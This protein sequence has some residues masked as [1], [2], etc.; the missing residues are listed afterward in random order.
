MTRHAASRGPQ[1]TLER[2][3]RA[4]V[5]P[6]T[7]DEA[8]R[9]VVEHAGGPLLVLAGPGTGKTTTLVEAIVDRIEERGADPAS[10]L[11]LTF[12][13]KAAEQLR[14]RVTAR[15]GRTVASPISSTFHS[16]AYSLV[17]RFTPADLYAAPLRLLT[18]PQADVMVRDLLAHHG[19]SLGWPPGLA[20]AARTRG[21]AK[22]VAA[23][24]AR[25]REKGAD[26]EQLVAL[27]RDSDIPEFV[28]AGLFLEH[29]LTNLD[30]HGATDY[31]DLVRRAVIEAQSHREELRREFSHVFVDEYQDTDPGQVALLRAI[32]GDGLNLVAVGDPHQSIYGFRGAEVR[33]ILDF[34]TQFP[35][36]T[37]ERAPVVVLGTTRRF[38]H[39]IL[40]AATRVSDNLPLVGGIPAE[41]A[42]AFARPTPAPGTAAGSVEVSTYDTERAEAEHI[43]DL[44][45]REHLE[46]GTRW[47][48]MAVLARSGRATLPVLRRLLSAA[49]VPVEVAADEIP[50][51]E[52]PSVRP[53]LDALEVAVATADEESGTPTAER[54][55]AL[56]LSPLGGLEALELR[57]L[58][59]SLRQREVTLAAAE[60]RTARG[61]G[62]L[63]AEA[64]VRPEALDELPEEVAAK[65]RRL[66]TL[67][68]DVGAQAADGV[69]VERL[70][71]QLW[72]ATDW[73]QRL[74]RAVLKGGV[75][76]RRAHRDLDAVCALFDLAARTEQ[77]RGRT[78]A[79]SFLAEV[80][81]QQIPADTLADKGVRGEAVRLLTAHRS[82]GLEWPVV[83]VAHVQDGA[84]PDLRRRAT[85][86]GAD[87]ITADV[88]GH[89]V[90]TRD[91]SAAALLAEERRLFYVACT[92]ARRRLVVTAVASRSEDGEQASRFLDEVMPAGPDGERAPVPH[93]QG[94]P[95]RPLTM[96]GVV[97][98]LRRCVGDE[99]QPEPLRRA[100]ALRLAALAEVE[101]NGRALVPAADPAT[102]WGT[103][104]RSHSTQP[105]R[106]AEEPV[107]LSASTVTAVADCPAKWFLEHEA[108]GA[109]FSGQGAA[110]GNIVHKVAEHVAG[111]DLADATVDDLMEL[112]DQVWAQLPF[113]TPWSAEKEREEARASIERFLNAHRS[114]DARTVVGTEK[115]FSFL[116]TLPDGQQV[117]LRGFADRVEVT[118]DGTVVVVDLKTGKYPPSAKEVADHPQLGIYQYAVEQGALS[119]VVGPDARSGGA[120]LWQLRASTQP[121]PKIQAQ[122]P[123]SRDEEGWLLAERQ[124]AETART[125]RAEE[126]P[127]LPG[128]HCRFCP[129]RAMC[130]AR[131]TAGV[132]R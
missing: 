7:L 107:R 36:V 49:G 20:V 119:D 76:A 132:I 32:A 103:H 41:V 48:D 86:L 95:P 40:A 69:D 128:D 112:V 93:V 126:F 63:V 79:A 45:R 75:G 72:S 9:S 58:G 85:L 2:P 81:A 113:R 66:G 17:R 60:R 59:R 100:A 67:L 68:V 34:P 109:V 39:E 87:R 42:H 99:G 78:S 74:R 8:Q 117:S 94:R 64:L 1:V 97:A 73:G 80:T 37:G 13:R 19:P 30:D 115:S 114:P 43:A 129:F 131:T 46:H 56:L 23:V 110:F 89:L 44:L 70:L 15:L 118:T 4:A 122:A 6:P 125:I 16:F 14:D 57:A 21:F 98:E 71:W 106:P 18:A 84:W 111:G 83:V 116:A 24:V 47:S 127:A 92:R 121:R 130:P 29:Y 51:G 96:S 22:E 91:L 65:A 124:L 11:A 28:A 33:G 10:V 55:E 5:V 53:L 38:G 54:A 52:E 61:S 31:P 62:D 102:W 25:A 12:S 101:V 105:V 123:Q 90:L 120:E 108:G 77:V 82:K 35:Q 88:Y 27:G 26:H 50:L 104:A 3:V